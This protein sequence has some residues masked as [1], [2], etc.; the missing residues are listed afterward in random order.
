MPY[1]TRSSP[2]GY[3]IGFGADRASTRL[4][5]FHRGMDAISF[6][7]VRGERSWGMSITDTPP[8]HYARACEVRA[9]PFYQYLI[10]RGCTTRARA[11]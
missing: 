2:D 3:C 5:Q 6:A 10:E 1:K 8:L 4:V 9:L 7:P 11:R